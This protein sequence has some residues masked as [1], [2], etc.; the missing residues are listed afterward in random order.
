MNEKEQI[1]NMGDNTSRVF[2]G[3]YI[4]NANKE[5]YAETAEFFAK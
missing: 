4:S 1:P 3:E 2:K 5:M